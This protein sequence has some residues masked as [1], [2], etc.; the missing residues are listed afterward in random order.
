M[1]LKNRQNEARNVKAIGVFVFV[2]VIAAGVM[3]FLSG[4]MPMAKAT[5]ETEVASSEPASGENSVAAATVPNNMNEVTPGNPVV[6]KVGEAEITRLEVLQFINQLPPNMRQLPIQQLFPM[7]VE[8]VV[9]ARIIDSQVQEDEIAK[10]EDVQQQIETARQQIIRNAYIEEQIAAK[11]TGDRLQEAYDAYAKAFERV[12]EAKASHILV[13]E[14]QTAK[15]IIARLDDG[16]SFED[17]AKE[18][19]LDATAQNGGELGFFA[20]AEVVPEFAEAAFSLKKGEYT[21]EPVQ[22]QFGF[23]VIK[24]QEFRKREPAPFEEAKPFLET[25]LR[26]SILDE[27]VQNWR[28]TASIELF[29]INGD[30]LEPAAGDEDSSDTAE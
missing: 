28:Q 14:E 27:I 26:R 15:D 4:Q 18:L 12:D 16:E 7:A 23:H 13:E 1:R 24:T 5:T 10:Q 6:A 22:S 30:P 9:N 29:N 17:L 19:S 20:K 11:M 2:A 3:A 8:Q 25:Q 21:K